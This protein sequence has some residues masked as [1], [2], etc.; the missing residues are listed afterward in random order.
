[1]KTFKK[2]LALMIAV[3]MCM[4]MAISVYADPTP[5][6]ITINSATGDTQAHTYDVYQ[7]FAGVSN[8][9]TEAD[10][11]KDPEI[12]TVT[13]GSSITDPA[14]FISKL[15]TAFAA[16]T[17]IAALATTD[18]AGVVAGA[19]GTLDTDDKDSDDAKA[20]AAFMG[21]YF[22]TN[23]SISGTGTGTV[24]VE[25]PSDGY[26]FIKD[27]SN[28]DATDTNRDKVVG[29]VEI[30]AKASV[31]S[32][33]KF[34]DDENDSTTAED[35]I[36]WTKTADYDID[37]IIPYHIKGTLPSNYADYTRYNYIFHDEMCDGLTYD[38]SLGA[39]KVVLYANETAYQADVAAKKGYADATGADITD[40]FTPAFDSQELTVSV[41][42]FAT[43]GDTQLG[44]KLLNGQGSTPTVTKDSVIV[45][46]YYAKLTGAEVVYGDDG[47]DNDVY[48]EFSNNPNAGGEGD[49]G[50]TP[51]DTN[52]VFTYKVEVD[53]VDE[54]LDAL[55]GAGFALFKKISAPTTAQTSAAI[56][57][58]TA[59]GVT[60]TEGETVYKVG[61][62][63][64]LLIKNWP[65]NTANNIFQYSGIDD[66]EYIISETVVPTGYNKAADVTFTVAAGTKTDATST[67]GYK[68]DGFT[69]TSEKL[70]G[71]VA[72]AAVTVTEG[73][74]TYTVAADTDSAARVAGVIKNQSGTVLPETGGIGTTMFY[75]IG[76]VLIIGA[77]IV[78]VTRRRMS[79]N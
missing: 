35:T 50:E 58:L 34:V 30:T 37:D 57:D 48:L 45:V 5:Y 65:E 23:S 61:S 77:G 67:T 16:N 11:P 76:A 42:N 29:D 18:T 60:L 79:A 22:T 32:V 62:D 68:L 49:T 26:Y 21:T 69:V 36:D 15:K 24:T 59:D 12:G 25:V 39:A 43:T 31:P 73:S 64:Y 38:T 52:V 53:K 9:S 74:N 2:M 4:A 55:K 27:R 41:K 1:M 3:V 10:D 70:E 17:K 33:E 19:I 72:G 56:D 66:G 40:Y 78:L 75:I 6:N 47:N 51:K 13:W 44:L 20:L 54:N 7:I 63:Y 8:L 71:D 46:Y 14:D 28:P